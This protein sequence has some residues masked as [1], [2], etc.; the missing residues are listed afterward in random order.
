[1]HLLLLRWLF[2]RRHRVPHYGDTVNVWLPFCVFILPDGGASGRFAWPGFASGGMFNTMVAHGQKAYTEWAHRFTTR[3]SA[4][5]VDEIAAALQGAPEFK[6]GKTFITAAISQYGKRLRAS[7]AVS[8]DVRRTVPV[9]WHFERSVDT[10]TAGLLATAAQLKNKRLAIERQQTYLSDDVKLSLDV[11]P[12]A[13]DRELYLPHVRVVRDV[14]PSEVSGELRQYMEGGASGQA[15]VFS[16]DARMRVLYSVLGVKTSDDQS[17]KNVNALLR[18]LNRDGGVINSVTPEVALGMFAK[19]RFH[20]EKMRQQMTVIGY[21]AETIRQV[22]QKLSDPTVYQAV[23]V[24]SLLGKLTVG[25]QFEKFFALSGKFVTT[26]VMLGDHT[27]VI[28]EFLYHVGV[29]YIIDRFFCT[30]LLS[31]V[32]VD[33]PRTVGE[34][35]MK[36][37]LRPHA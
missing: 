32:H 36:Q 37:V 1:M 21:S 25:G 12:V 9:K 29:Q 20:V 35:I 7:R 30:G 6:R 28:R 18:I 10:F 27:D 16:S 17:R 13:F 22:L 19:V 34:R 11:K 14:S 5:D 15:P 23:V 26:Y 33:L 31:V 3:N 24:E 2:L 8:E 4:T